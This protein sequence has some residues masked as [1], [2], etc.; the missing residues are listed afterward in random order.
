LALVEHNLLAL[1]R[2][3]EVVEV[4]HRVGQHTLVEGPL[5][6]NLVQ[7]DMKVGLAS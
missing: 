4:V 3:L 7:A 6:H 1:G 5:E 2:S